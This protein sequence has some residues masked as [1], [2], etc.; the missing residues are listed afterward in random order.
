[1]LGI[2]ITGKYIK[3]LLISKKGST[4]VMSIMIVMIMSLLGISIM[5]ATLGSL[6]MSVMYSDV[7]RAYFAAEA[8][9]EEIAKTIDQKV[10]DIQEEARAQA[11]EDIQL[12]LEEN[13]ITLRDSDGSLELATSEPDNNDSKIEH[14]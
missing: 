13:P 1:M 9:A 14:E 6:D 2:K 10:S 7:N 3:P 12:L 5:A 4:L 11:T 8:A